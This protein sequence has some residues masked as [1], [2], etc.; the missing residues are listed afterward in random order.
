VVAAS[1]PDL[2]PDGVFWFAVVWIRVFIPVD[3]A[4]SQYFVQVDIGSFDFKVF[5]EICGHDQLDFISEL[6]NHPIIVHCT[7]SR[8]EEMDPFVMPQI[9]TFPFQAG[10]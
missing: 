2:A 7:I 1:A 10:I 8:S 4:R 9:Q 5:S 3:R 6:A